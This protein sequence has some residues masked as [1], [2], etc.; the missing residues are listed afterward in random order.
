MYQ[1]KLP[2]SYWSYALLHVVFL[3]NRVSTPLLQ[4][5]SPY[6]MLHQKLPDINT[7]KVFGCLCHAS[8]LQSHRTK[9]QARARKTVFL[10]YKPGYK[11]FLL[12][13]INSREI[14]VSR[15]VVFHEHYL[16]YPSNN[17]SITTQWEYFSPTPT[18]IHTSESVDTIS[19]LPLLMMMIILHHLLTFHLLILHQIHPLMFLTH[20]FT[21]H[22][23]LLLIFFNHPENQQEIKLHLFIFR[24]I[25]VTICISLL[26]IFPTICLIKIY[27]TLILILSCLCIHTLNL[28]TMLRQI[29]MNVGIKLCKLNCQLLRQLVPGR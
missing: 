12:L 18:P 29:S 7:F 17:E 10:G 21:P 26:N 16:P 1:S 20:L 24:I 28:K 14:F 8:S 9:L 13:D 6:Y 5:Q 19:P 2:A 25:S 23:I 15:H 11:G 4:G 3:I 22:L 27:L